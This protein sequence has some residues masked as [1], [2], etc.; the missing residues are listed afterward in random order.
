MTRTAGNQVPCRPQLPGPVITHY[1]GNMCSVPL[2][3]SISTQ[4]TGHKYL[5]R[6]IYVRALGQILTLIQ[7]YV[8]LYFYAILILAGHILLLQTIKEE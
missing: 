6:E 1:Y 8:Q 2:P 3:S 5:R 7:I 4:I